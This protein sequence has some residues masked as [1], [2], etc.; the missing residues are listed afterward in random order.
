MVMRVNDASRS[1]LERLR[2]RRER[3]KAA[4][5]DTEAFRLVDGEGDGMPDLWVDVLG[6]HWLVQAKSRGVPREWRELVETGICDSIWLKQLS[7]EVRDAPVCVMGAA[8]AAFEVMEMG[9]KMEIQP[10][11]G[12]SCGLF[13]DQR[14][15]RARVRA[16]V[17][18]GGRVL[19]LFSYTCSFSVA[20]ALGGASATSVDLNAG[21]LEWGK[22]NFG[23]NGLDPAAH[24]WIKGDSFDWLAAFAKK[25]KRFDGVIL[26]PPTFSRGTKKRVFRV[27]QD[28][29]ELVTLAAA[30]VE[31]GGWLLACA[32]THRLDAMTFVAAVEAGLAQAGRRSR[33]EMAPLPMPLDFTG[34]SYLKA[35]WLEVTE[36]PS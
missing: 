16:A 34:P 33:R 2:E 5:V 14:D 7:R 11:S 30:V 36:G 6:R 18:P 35:L 23:L 15:N 17:R 32:N 21:Y 19:N 12:Y 27:E 4:G 20:A 29:A 24:H 10:A 31:P 13:L 25:G 3:L 8:P 22:R 26:D 9:M 28:Y 1:I